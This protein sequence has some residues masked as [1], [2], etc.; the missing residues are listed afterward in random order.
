[1]TFDHDYAIIRRFDHRR[2]SLLGQTS[3]NMGSLGRP[4]GPCSLSVKKASSSAVGC[5]QN[6]GTHANGT[7]YG[8]CG[9]SCFGFG[10]GGVASGCLDVYDVARSHAG[11]DMIVPLMLRY[12]SAAWVLTTCP[13]RWPTGP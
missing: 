3:W 4:L 6:V 9:S 7:G 13:I 2:V 12:A 10:V 1:L 11:G 5:H 8:G